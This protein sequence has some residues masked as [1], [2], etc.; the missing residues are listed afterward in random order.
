MITGEIP[1]SS[2]D[3]LVNK[4]SVRDELYE[5]YKDLG[6]CPQ[7]DALFPL[8]T[9]REHLSFYSMLR[10]IP[11]RN[12]QTVSEWSLKRF[13]LEPMA[14]RIASGKFFLKSQVFIG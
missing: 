10:G 12:I 2:G 9:T 13:E 7:N 14:D 11:Q 6:Y 5:V 1:I 3:V 8:L 4:K